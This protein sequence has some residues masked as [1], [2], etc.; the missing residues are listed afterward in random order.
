M[1]KLKPPFYKSFDQ[2]N[3]TKVWVEGKIG[4]DEPLF[5]ISNFDSRSL[6]CEFCK[7]TSHNLKYAILHRIGHF[8]PLED[9]FTC[10]GCDEVFKTKTDKVSHIYFCQNK[11]KVN[12]SDCRY[13][14]HSSDNYPALLRH[15]K[16]LHG[17]NRGKKVCHI[18]Y[19]TVSLDHWTAHMTKH[20]LPDEWPFECDH[21]SK[22]FW[23]YRSIKT[24]LINKHFQ[25]LAKYPCQVCTEVYDSKY[26]LTR[27]LNIQHKIGEAKSYI[28]LGCGKKFASAWSLAQ[29]EAT[30]HEK[31]PKEKRHSCTICSKAF[32]RRD[33]LRYHMNTHLPEAEKPLKCKHCGKGF[34]GLNTLKYH[35]REHTNPEKNMCYCDICGKAFKYSG[36]LKDHKILHTGKIIISLDS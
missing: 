7:I 14:Y 18:C 2:P 17:P 23:S 22:K 32:F 6:H 29:H 31:K 1:E 12:I 24:H 16:R 35:E 25:Y 5:R 8:F 3:G 20:R 26:R 28:C 34:S 19:N 9:E 33:Q 10:M 13:C 30:F 27:H 4:P 36:S 15:T 11:D 21:C